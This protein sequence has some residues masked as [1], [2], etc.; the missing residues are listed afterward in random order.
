MAAEWAEILTEEF[1]HQGKMEAELEMA[2][3]LFGGPPV[4]NDI[5]KMGASQTGFINIFGIPLFTKVAQALPSMHFTV[6]E[7]QANKA[8]WERLMEEAKKRHAKNIGGPER[9]HSPHQNRRSSV[10]AQSQMR[11]DPMVFGTHSSMNSPRPPK[12]HSAGSNSQL[13]QGGL[14]ASRRASLGPTVI[15]SGMGTPNSASR[16]SSAGHAKMLLGASKLAEF[17]GTPGLATVA[18]PEMTGQIDGSN[19]E[20]QPRKS[21]SLPMPGLAAQPEVQALLRNPPDFTL[22]DP[23]TGRNIE[24]GSGITEA[25]RTGSAHSMRGRDK[26]PAAA[27]VDAAEDSPMP[28]NRSTTSRSRRFTL[29][30][31]RKS[32]SLDRANGRS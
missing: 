16:R 5:A 13:S 21:N 14:P 22:R 27:R 31:W 1:A 24:M 6:D 26:M 19:Y 25:P 12:R 23:A 11:A 15:P 29:K 4:Q 9:T 10:I 32:R 28:S 20:V 30:F 8:E 17:Q 2:S 7:L 18:S 3:C